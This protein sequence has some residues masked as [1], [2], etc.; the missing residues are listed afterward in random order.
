ML[1]SYSAYYAGLSTALRLAQQLARRNK[2]VSLLEVSN[3]LFI[4]LR[5]SHRRREMYCGHARLCFCL[6]VCV[7]VRGRMPTL[8]LIAWTRI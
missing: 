2:L 5:V 8:L 4:T 3:V 1:E 6:S 7:S